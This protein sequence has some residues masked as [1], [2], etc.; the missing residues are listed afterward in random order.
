MVDIFKKSY[1][2][3]NGQLI[4]V[5]SFSHFSIDKISKISTNYIKH[6]CICPDINTYGQ[7][8]GVLFLNLKISQN[9]HHVY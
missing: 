9:T 3:F 1:L 6:V 7:T 2:I 8:A 4:V 5:F